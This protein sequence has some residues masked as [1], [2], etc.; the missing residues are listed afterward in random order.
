MRQDDPEEFAI[1]D[2]TRAGSKLH[3]VIYGVFSSS[4]SAQQAANQFTGELARLQPW[5]R[6]IG[7]VQDAAR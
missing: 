1:Y 2:I 4:A 6:P 3:V 7:L 5:V